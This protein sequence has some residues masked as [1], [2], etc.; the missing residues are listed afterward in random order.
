MKNIDTGIQLGDLFGKRRMADMA[1]ELKKQKDLATSRIVQQEEIIKSQAIVIKMLC[2]E[3][4]SY[5]EDTIS[6]NDRLKK[7]LAGAMAMQKSL[8][9]YAE[10][11]EKRLSSTTLKS[12]V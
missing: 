4:R 12:T 8:Q 6:E 1:F 9:E 7:S 10:S 5:K 2:N 3:L 11:L